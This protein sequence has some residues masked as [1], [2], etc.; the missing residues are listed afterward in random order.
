MHEHVG[1][2][3]RDQPRPRRGDIQLRRADAY[4]NFMHACLWAKSRIFGRLH[5]LSVK[6]RRSAC[7]ADDWPRQPESRPHR[8]YL[9]GRT[10][11]LL[12]PSRGIRMVNFSGSFS[13]PI[14][15]SRGQQQGPHAAYRY[16]HS[17]RRPC[18]F[19]RSRDAGARR[20]R[21]RRGRSAS[22]LS[23]RSPLRKARWSAGQ[24]SASHRARRCGAACR[25]ARRRMLDRALRSRDREARRRPVRHPLRHARQYDPRRDSRARRIHQRQ[26]QHGR[27][28]PG[29]ARPASKSPHGW[30]W[31]P[32]DS[33][34]VCGTPSA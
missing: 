8:S 4:R 3:T 23:A 20:L 29:P 27:E 14:A 13:I 12:P 9:N 24:C 7:F 1:G 2:R 6:D 11:R 19:N 32:T 30:S 16:R 10:R 5:C 25:H 31:S 33:I 15:M 34:S 26:G 22:R 18:G 28:Q 21:R 17:R